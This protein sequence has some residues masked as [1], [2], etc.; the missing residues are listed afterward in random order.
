MEQEFKEL[1]YNIAYTNIESLL[2]S[3]KLE[4]FEIFVKEAKELRE[5]ELAEAGL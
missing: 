4:L 2:N 3:E 1:V 5:K